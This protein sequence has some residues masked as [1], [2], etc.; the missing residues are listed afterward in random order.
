VSAAGAADR[1]GVPPRHARG[2][3]P[4]RPLA[5]RV[6]DCRPATGVARRHCYRSPPR[7]RDC[8]APRSRS[9]C[10]LDGPPAGAGRRH[11]YRSPPRSRDCFA[12]RSRSECGLDGP[13]AGAGRRHCYRSPPQCCVADRRLVSPG[14]IA[15]ARR[16]ARAIASL[17]ASR[18]TLLPH[19]QKNG[20]RFC[21]CRC[22]FSVIRIYFCTW[23]KYLPITA[24]S[25]S[26]A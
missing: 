2:R 19:Q 5:L 17:R 23:S 3:P 25:V 22:V 26:L 1:R 8:F 21:G 4:A 13:P 10:G 12:P 11:C 16:R 18:K 9:E 15:I 24:A 14:G 6:R 7:S 20:I